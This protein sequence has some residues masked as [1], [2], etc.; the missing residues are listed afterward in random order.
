[1]IEEENF[2]KISKSERISLKF[3]EILECINNNTNN[4]STFSN[5]DFEEI[6]NFKKE[7]KEQ[8]ICN[9]IDEI[10]DHLEQENFTLYVI[11]DFIKEKFQ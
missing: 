11:I 6:E 9:K 1:M 3:N 7:I 10:I 8:E 5:I 2:N 4:T